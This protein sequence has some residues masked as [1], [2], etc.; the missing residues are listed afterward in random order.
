L[1]SLPVRREAA[2]P[3]G[4][5]TEGATPPTEREVMERRRSMADVAAEFYRPKTKQDAPAAAP[6]G[7]KVTIHDLV[8]RTYPDRGG[9]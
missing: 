7:P 4:K 3:G 8:R 5:S 9:Q 2:D 1:V 6:A